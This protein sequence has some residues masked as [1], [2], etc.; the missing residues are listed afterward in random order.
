MR[1]LILLIAW[2]LVHWVGAGELPFDRELINRH[3]L[4]G[5]PR[6]LSIRQG[7]EH[8]LGYDLER[9]KVFKA[10]RAPGG[11]PGLELSGFVTKSV[12][13]VKFEDASADSW[14][15]QRAGKEVPLSIRYLG[16]SQREKA[17]DLRWEL[18]HDRGRIELQQRVPMSAAEAGGWQ[19]EIRGEGLAADEVLLLP[20]A[21]NQSW[22]PTLTIGKAAAGLSDSEWHRFILP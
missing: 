18:R 2:S 17:F 8:W 6:S 20:R 13:K 1:L 16:C 9:A 10:W 4:D 7:R 5:L 3:S 12:G 19:I 15:L 14:R 21:L 11:K 22:K